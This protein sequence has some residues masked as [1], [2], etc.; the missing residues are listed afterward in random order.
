[1]SEP[2]PNI[3]QEGIAPS[4]EMAPSISEAAQLYQLA[5][6]QQSATPPTATAPDAQPME[7]IKDVVMTDTLMDGIAVSICSPSCAGPDS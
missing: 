6:Q 4:S 7:P 1:M 2:M 5:M 3:P